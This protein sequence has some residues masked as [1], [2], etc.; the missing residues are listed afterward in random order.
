MFPDFIGICGSVCLWR[1]S[2]RRK[3]RGQCIIESPGREMVCPGQP[4]AVPH[5]LIT[6]PDFLSEAKIRYGR[7]EVD[8]SLEIV[9]NN[10]VLV[11]PAP[12]E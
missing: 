5:R 1:T 10:A 7:I 12:G 4:I 3:K 8:V 11:P 9:D 2:F 6:R